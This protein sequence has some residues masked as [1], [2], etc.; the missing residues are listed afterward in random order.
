[1]EH[2]VSAVLHFV[3]SAGYPETPI[4]GSNDLMNKVYKRS[5]NVHKERAVTEAMLQFLEP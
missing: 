4:N 2:A 3:G 5:I 1:M